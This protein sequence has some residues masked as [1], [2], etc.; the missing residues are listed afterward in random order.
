[1]IRGHAAWALARL[2]DQSNRER[3]LATLKLLSEQENDPAV[4]H[5]FMSA[6]QGI[7]ELL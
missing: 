6:I 4:L 2:T 1:L 3:V 7:R 5:E